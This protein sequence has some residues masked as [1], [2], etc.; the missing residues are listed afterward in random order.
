[1]ESATLRYARFF[2]TCLQIFEGNE[3]QVPGLRA[4]RLADER[5]LT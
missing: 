3:V 5:C 2:I 1:M 4:D